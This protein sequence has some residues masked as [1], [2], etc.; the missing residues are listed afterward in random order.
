[1]SKKKKKIAYVSG[2]RA[3]YGLMTSILKAIDNNEVDIFNVSISQ[4]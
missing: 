1:M 4:P 3:D 2:T